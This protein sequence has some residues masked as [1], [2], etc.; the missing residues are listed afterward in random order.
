MNKILG[1]S[2]LSFLVFFSSLN[3]SLTSCTKEKIV[4]IKK[5]T[6]IQK[7]TVLL[8]DT[9][10][11]LEIL[12]ANPW[13]LQEYKGVVGNKKVWYERGSSNNTQNFDSDYITFKLDK[14]GQY[15]DGFGGQYAIT[16]DFV[17]SDSTKIKW[18]YNR[19]QGKLTVT[20]DNIRYKNASLLFDQYWT[21][22]RIH[23]HTQVVRT[24]KEERKN[25]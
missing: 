9:A 22:K 25:F 12:T 3:V 8:K 2:I 1:A 16:W 6:I 20:Y 21:D 11:T 5:D 18:V 7:D 15:T 14:T 17:N 19:P 24:P 4:I 10:L 13:Q 23:S